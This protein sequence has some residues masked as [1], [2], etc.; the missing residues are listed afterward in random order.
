MYVFSVYW[1]FS[2]P[3]L[4]T[5]T[6]PKKEEAEKQVLPWVSIYFIGTLSLEL[7]AAISVY[8]FTNTVVT[9]GQ[10]HFSVPPFLVFGGKG[11]EK[12]EAFGKR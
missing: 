11:K 12:G 6:Q 2:P 3:P 8:Y 1:L 7:P 5:A 4:S 10:R 9:A